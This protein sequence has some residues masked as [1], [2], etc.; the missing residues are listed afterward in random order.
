MT[1]LTP[2]G[3]NFEIKPGVSLPAWLK[4]H[5]DQESGA[6]AILDQSGLPTGV[7][8]HL[9]RGE[10]HDC[11]ACAYLRGNDEC[12]YPLRKGE[13]TQATVDATDLDHCF[14]DSDGWVHFSPE[15]LVR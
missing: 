5:P 4:D 11:G 15:G 14:F 9:L 6:L 8:E 3:G 10:I 7:V 1:D 12:G 2:S 13:I